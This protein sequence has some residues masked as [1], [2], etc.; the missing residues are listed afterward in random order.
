MK[1]LPIKIARAVE[2]YT[3]LLDEERRSRV[4]IRLDAHVKFSSSDL[5]PRSASGMLR[6]GGALMPSILDE[7]FKGEL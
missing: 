6:E 3:R 7:A 1:F 2:K 4:H 5:P